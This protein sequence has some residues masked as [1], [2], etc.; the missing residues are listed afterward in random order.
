[1]KPSIT[2]DQG[3]I[4]LETRQRNGALNGLDTIQWNRSISCEPE[5]KALAYFA[6]AVY[7]RDGSIHPISLPNGTTINNPPGWVLLASASAD[8]GYRGEAYC[9]EA[10][11]QLVISHCGTEPAAL[12]AREGSAWWNVYAQIRNRLNQ[13]KE[14]LG[15]AAETFKD[16]KADFEGVMQGQD[17]SQIST[18]EMFTFHILECLRDVQKT[19]SM[20]GH[21]L[22]GWL[23]QLVAYECAPEGALT[24]DLSDPI[25]V[26]TV[27]FESPG[28]REIVEW[29]EFFKTP[30]H[31]ID[32]DRDLDITNYLSAPNL[33]NTCNG[34]LGSVYRLYPSLSMDMS[35]FRDW[36]SYTYNAHIIVNLLPL[37][38]T[39]SS[40]PAQLKRVI[41]WPQVHWDKMQINSLNVIKTIWKGCVGRANSLEAILA[42][43]GGVDASAFEAL[44]KF[45][46]K[47]NQYEPSDDD[48]SF[49]EYRELLRG[50]HY[51]L[52]S[53]TEANLS[54]PARTFGQQYPAIK[55]GFDLYRILMEAKLLERADIPSVEVLKQTLLIKDR[56][57]A[58]FLPQLL[59]CCSLGKQ[60]IKLE[61]SQLLELEPSL[62]S[63][64]LRNLEYQTVQ[65]I[66]GLLRRFPDL[67]DMARRGILEMPSQLLNKQ[68]FLEKALLDL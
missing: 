37:F 53:L 51:Q 63:Q 22:G 62:R 20:T 47:T 2:Q 32:I 40:Y 26:H 48:L 21:S 13:A 50:S 59:L 16:L 8:D 52:E 4:D 24:K 36:V 34:H 58:E 57:A 66:K 60:R 55:E 41:T 1:M 9:H 64:S 49:E 23:A 44:F 5:D 19:I 54:L 39:E 67:P 12:P 3:L 65:W 27:V 10:N 30:D 33:I 42:T 14:A 31:R 6:A 18:A 43:L 56:T 28:A 15:S 25:Q 38:E 17:A 11:R 46:K 7:E 29:Y 68:N 45:S 61:I 35:G